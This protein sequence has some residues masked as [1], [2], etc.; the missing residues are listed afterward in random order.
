MGVPM[1]LEEMEKTITTL[2]ASQAKKDKELAEL[3]TFKAEVEKKEKEAASAC[4]TCGSK[5]HMTAEHKDAK[6]ADK[7]M[8]EEEKKEEEKKAMMKKAEEDKKTED[9]KKAMKATITYL[10]GIVKQPK[11]KTLT[12]AFEGRV[13]DEKLKSFSA[14]WTK[15]SVEQL[16]AEI[17]KI[18][19]LLESLGYEAE[20]NETPIPL[21]FS[22][23][24]IPAMEGSTIKND[25]Y[26]ASVD[27]MSVEDLFGSSS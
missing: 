9:E 1:T 26:L 21:G 25:T 7:D 16:D 18:T 12:A 5:E 20:T 4:A 19:P 8:T 3:L 17:D 11:I 10:E 2:Q 27:K 13:D 22:S 23:P 14:S 6:K 15:M 24:E